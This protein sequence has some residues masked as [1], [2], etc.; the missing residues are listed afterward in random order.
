M[1]LI[2]DQG[3]GKTCI[4]KRYV[5]K[6]FDHNK[7]ATSGVDFSNVKYTSTSG[8][9]CRVKIW[10]TAGQ[11]RYRGLTNSFFKE[12]DGIIVVFDLTNH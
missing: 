6:K 10:D 12:A 1:I 5:N 2:G 9:D 7:M 8:E 4:L 11:E 3:V